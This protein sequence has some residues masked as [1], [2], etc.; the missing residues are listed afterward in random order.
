MLHED[1]AAGTTGDKYLYQNF[2]IC[3]SY[4]TRKISNSTSNGLFIQ[5]GIYVDADETGHLYLS[6]FDT[7]PLEPAF[8][9]FGSRN[10]DVQIMNAHIEV[11]SEKE[12]IKIRCNPRSSY[13]KATELSCDYKCHLACDG[14]YKPHS[15]YHCKKCMHATIREANSKDNISL[16]CELE[17]PKGYKSVGL[18]KLCIGKNFLIV[19]I[20]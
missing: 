14:C 3:L 6:Y 2:F 5:Y 16:I 15:K 11:L 8:Y 1:A 7:E 10:S 4:E 12:Q 9:S 13:S 17:C 19:F 18:N 20:L